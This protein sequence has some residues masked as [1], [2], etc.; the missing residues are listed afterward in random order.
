MSY[1]ARQC[2]VPPHILQAMLEHPALRARAQRNLM[3]STRMRER[4]A[5]FQVSPPPTPTGA[6]R[7]TIYDAREGSQLPGH[8]VRPEDGPA[9]SD[10]AVNEAYDGL[11][12]T[13]LLFSEVYER[14]S[15]DDRGM[16]L[17]ATVHFEHEYDNA[18]W[19]GRQMVFGD[20]DGVVFVGFTRALDVIGHE[21]THGVVEHT[22][23]L[24][25]HNQ[26]G[27]LNESFADVFGSLVKQYK[28]KQTAA[29]A[30]W[31]VGQEILAPGIRGKALR[32]LKEPG[33]AYDDPRIGKDPQPAHMDD[34][35]HLADTEWEDWGGVHINSGIP[36]HAF[37][38]LAT[39]LGGY[40]WEAPGRI[41][42]ETLRQLFPMAEFQHCAD[43]S[44]DVAGRQFGSGSR[45]QLA[46]AEAWDAVGVK[47]QKSA[48]H[49]PA[50][51]PRPAPQPAPG[52][53][54]GDIEEQLRRLVRELDRAVQQLGRHG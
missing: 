2:I 46:V 45:E 42:Y 16:R 43:I 36:N 10:V 28:W 34:Y 26:S 53:V 9:S 11:G 32:S 54:R 47:I 44:H 23:G 4:R 48:K 1:C 17:D 25:Y 27:A 31:L 7:R 24:V 38:R 29:E 52:D 19:D 30:D 21:L 18:F 39:R 20:G 8:L 49:A 15:I 5:I 50:P 22:A 41:W 51:A 14:N 35:R 3:T 12:D 40:A 13:Y 33:T 37:Y 6:L